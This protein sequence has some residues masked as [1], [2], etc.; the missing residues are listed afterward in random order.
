MPRHFLPASQAGFQIGANDSLDTANL[1]EF[2]DLLKLR[3][4]PIAVI[5]ERLDGGI[6]TDLVSILKGICE[7]F[8]GA[9]DAD[10]HAIDLMYLDAGRV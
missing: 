2:H 1:R 3:L 9:I 7:G 6:E 10:G 5:A 8:L 4:A